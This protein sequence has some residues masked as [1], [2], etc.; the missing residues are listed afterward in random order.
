MICQWGRGSK[1]K[2]RSYLT[3]EKI[4]KTFRRIFGEKKKDLGTRTKPFKE[5]F[6][7]KKKIRKNKKACK[8]KFSE[9]RKGGREVQ[10]FV[11]GTKRG[12][13]ALLK[14]RVVLLKKF[15]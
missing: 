13:S 3:S 8:G 6:R 5:Q 15:C 2:A 12:E 9:V 11:R 14:Q 10:P 1:K 7:S 4:T